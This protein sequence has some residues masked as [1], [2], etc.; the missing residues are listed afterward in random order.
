MRSVPD[1]LS[2]VSTPT[3]ALRREPAALAGSLQPLL[4]PA[5]TPPVPNLADANELA[6]LAALIGRDEPLSLRGITRVTTLPAQEVE[7]ALHSLRQV[8]LVLRL[9]T[10]VD[11]YAA[12]S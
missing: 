12:R 2:L 7:R 6:V 8:G 9:N 10:L 3:H 5:A 1:S 11:S 4:L